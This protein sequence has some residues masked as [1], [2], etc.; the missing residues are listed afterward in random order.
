NEELRLVCQRIRQVIARENNRLCSRVKQLKERSRRLRRSKPL[1][2]FHRR[3]RSQTCSLIE[4]STGRHIQRKRPS[5]IR[6]ATDRKIRHLIAEDD[7]ILKSTAIGLA[8]EKIDFVANSAQRKP[9]IR[10]RLSQKWITIDN[11]IAICRN[12]RPA[13]EDEGARI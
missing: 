2:E 5:P 6:L 1:I 10:W 13:G 4:C 8:L 9:G 3:N 11:E 12:A 7:R